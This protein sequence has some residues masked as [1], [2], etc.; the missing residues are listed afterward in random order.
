MSA[1]ADDS[2]SGDLAVA[3]LPLPAG[4]R[5]KVDPAGRTYFANSVAKTTSYLHPLK[6]LPTNWTK[7]KD[8]QTGRYYYSDSKT[9]TTTY[10]H[11][12]LVPEG[13]SYKYDEAGC[14]YYVNRRLKT[15]SYQHPSVQMRSVSRSASVFNAATPV[16]ESPV[17]RRNSA[18]SARARRSTSLGGAH[19][20][21]SAAITRPS[22][23]PDD[24]TA[25]PAF[26]S[27][28]ARR[29]PAAITS[30]SRIDGGRSLAGP[31]GVRLLDRAAKIKIAQAFQQMR[32][33][34][35][36]TW[37]DLLR[38]SDAETKQL[39]LDSILAQ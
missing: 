1:V 32:A 27:P 28:A 24:S 30:G 13:Y 35:Q 18:A 5:E 34:D 12:F 39:V 31:L 7:K 2:D 16:G 8:K 38:T 20:R 4:W 26:E 33:S 23:I 3:G 14:V 15:T 36:K 22:T 11:P 17:G 25:A 9:R 37:I 21:N 29:S 19:R 10:E 6:D